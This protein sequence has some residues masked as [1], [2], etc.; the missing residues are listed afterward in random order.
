MPSLD[1]C[2]VAHALRGDAWMMLL[3]EGIGPDLL[4]DSGKKALKFIRKHFSEHGKLPEPETVETDTG[5]TIPELADV[6]EPAT[7]YL[8]RV[9]RRALDNLAVAATKAQVQALDRDD[10]DGALDAARELI[11]TI[12]K[13]N[14]TGEAIGDWTRSVDGRLADYDHIKGHPGGLTGVPTP[15]PG[16]N[17][18]TQG[19][20]PGDLW[21]LAARLGKGKCVAEGTLL[22]DPNTGV[23]RPVEEVVASQGDVWSL[24]LRGGEVVHRHPSAWVHTGTKECLTLRVRSGKTITVTPEHPMLTSG[25]WVRADELSVGSRIAAVAHYPEIRDPRPIPDSHVDLLAVLLSEGSLSGHHVGFSTSDSGF[26]GMASQAADDMGLLVKHRSRYDYDFVGA[27]GHPGGKTYLRSEFLPL[28]G[29]DRERSKEKRVP[30]AVF[31]LPNEQ[32]ARFLMVFWWGDGGVDGE[33][34]LASEGLIDDLQHLFLRLGVVMAKKYKRATCEGKEFDAWRLKVQS[35]CRE[36]FQRVVGNMPGEKGERIRSL[37]LAQN[38]NYDSVT[39]TEEI[40]RTIREAADQYRERWRERGERRGLYSEA[41]KRLGRKPRQTGLRDFVRKNGKP[42]V[43][44]RALRHLI[45]AA[46]GLLD[47]LSWLVSE[48]LY[49]TDILAIEDVGE[50]PVYDLTVPDTHCFVA[51]DL[52]VH[53]TWFLLKMALEAWLAGHNPLIVTMEMD[54]K[55]VERRLDA[56]WAKVAYK[57]LR[58]GLLGMH[59]EQHYRESLESLREAAPLHI[60]T[61]KRVKTPQDVAILCEQLKPG[62]VLVDGFYKMKPSGKGAYRAKWEQMVD[63]IDELQE[64]AQDKSVPV[65]V[66]TQ[67]NRE[68]TK[69]SGKGRNKDSLGSDDAGVEDLAFSDAIAMNADVVLALLWPD[70]LRAEGEILLKLLKNREDERKAWSVK[71]DLE[72]MEFDETGEWGGPPGGGGDDNSASVNY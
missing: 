31:R 29:L 4:F 70:D 18:L 22:P 35:W 40:E 11:A 27:E 54:R 44:R 47:S 37:P 25:G 36:R 16:L 65:L 66:S 14:L 30:E 58:R 32:L 24:D 2:L 67:F 13:Q 9:R 51:A 52:F 50:R 68:Q 1:L 26:L 43:G 60:V 38:P 53:N 46:D 72:G 62:I 7:Y 48:D 56:I 42:S 34:A 3:D 45:A 21:I 20:N 63:L 6:P 33:I 17:E 23:L 19:L 39:V 69:K 64:F 55:R 8:K 5:V 57:A 71:F 12:S 59:P 61:R 41:G 28:Y 10:V 15:W 49:F